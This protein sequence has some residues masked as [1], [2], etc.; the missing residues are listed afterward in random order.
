MG[1]DKDK[2]ESW[3][4]NIAEVSEAVEGVI[5][6]ETAEELAG[7]AKNVNDGNTYKGYTIKFS[8]DYH[9][10]IENIRDVI[11]FPRTPGNCEF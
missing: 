1:K 5:T 4:G 8:L 6:I 2:M 10:I 3:D 9:P 11:P 7:L